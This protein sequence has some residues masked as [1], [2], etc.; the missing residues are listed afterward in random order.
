MP[1]TRDSL[2]LDICLQLYFYL[3]PELPSI[4]LL[5]ETKNS[6]AKRILIEILLNFAAFEELH[7]NPEVEV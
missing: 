2:F 4:C 1:S 6:F 3:G 7:L 5:C